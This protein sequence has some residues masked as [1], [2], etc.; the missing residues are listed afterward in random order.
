MKKI[1]LLFVCL[2]VCWVLSAQQRIKVACVGNSITY[3]TGLSDRATQ[4]YPVKLQ[5]L[6]GERY[7]VENFGKPGAT[8]LNQGHRPYTRQEEYRKAL[9]FAGDIV[10]IHLGINDT[11]PRNWPNY[12]DF[13]VKDY[14]KL[15]DTFREANPAVRI[16]IARMTPIADRHTRFF[17]GNP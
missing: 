13:F 14:L 15:I 6:L 12:R 3:G 17:V 2:F 4:S 5:K 16:I 7:E 9:D 1:L 8:L 10:V 11:D